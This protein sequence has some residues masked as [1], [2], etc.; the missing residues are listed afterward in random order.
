MRVEK[1]EDA[2]IQ[3]SL[4]FA[5]HKIWSQLFLTTM[6]D[7]RRLATGCNQCVVFSERQWNIQEGWGCL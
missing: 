4:G 2:L 3:N 1:A 5:I 6:A 7:S